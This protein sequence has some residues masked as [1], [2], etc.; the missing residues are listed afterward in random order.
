[1]TWNDPKMAAELSNKYVEGLGQFL[2]SHAL[3]INFQSIDPALPPQGAFNRNPKQ[4]ALTGLAIGLFAGALM[5]F[6]L[7]Y[8]EK[9]RVP[10]NVDKN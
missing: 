10:T 7:E 8:L 9:L 2:N 5:A 1:M 6:F 4:K 3:N